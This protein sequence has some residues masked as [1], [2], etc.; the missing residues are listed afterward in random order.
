[1]FIARHREVGNKWAEIAKCLPGRTENAVKNHWN[2]TLRRKACTAPGKRD[3]L[4]KQYIL[5]ECQGDTGTGCCRRSA[6]APPPAGSDACAARDWPPAS[7]LDAHQGIPRRRHP[8]TG[9]F[10]PGGGDACREHTTGTSQA[11]PSR[12]GDGC[13][14]PGADTATVAPGLAL[15][16]LTPL[17]HHPAPSPPQFQRWLPASNR[18]SALPVPAQAAAGPGAGP[19]APAEAVL[20][21]TPDLELDCILDWLGGSPGTTPAS[22]HLASRAGACGAAPPPVSGRACGRRWR[23]NDTVGACAW[24]AGVAPQHRGAR[25]CVHPKP[26]FLPV[27]VNVREPRLPHPPD[28]AGALLAV[29]S[30]ERAAAAAVARRLPDA[31]GGAAPDPEWRCQAAHLLR[32][33]SPANL[34]R[35]PGMCSVCWMPCSTALAHHMHTLGVPGFGLHGGAGAIA[36]PTSRL[37]CTALAGLPLLGM[38]VGAWQCRGR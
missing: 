10:R 35:R 28:R 12:A 6:P 29:G 26:L 24:P 27:F 11:G 7:Q 37:S 18:L 25:G 13:P 17:S 36:G 4:L 8:R 21:L 20:P 23:R 1:M 19:G 31:A 32:R 38:G 15:A 3:S 16:C 9:S 2:A 30:Q 33:L 14:V 34:C 22:T 5:M